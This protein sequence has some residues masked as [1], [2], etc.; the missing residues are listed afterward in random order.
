[1]VAYSAT[2]FRRRAKEGWDAKDHTAQT[3]G[4]ISHQYRRCWW[5]VNTVCPLPFNDNSWKATRGN[6]FKSLSWVAFWVLAWCEKCWS[7]QNR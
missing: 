4:L 5:R 6:V 2:W 7:F 1:M 3:R